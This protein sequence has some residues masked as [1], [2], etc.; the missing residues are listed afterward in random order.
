MPTT[1]LIKKRPLSCQRPYG[2]SSFIIPMFMY[3]LFQA[4]DGSKPSDAWFGLFS[5]AHNTKKPNLIIKISTLK[6]HLR[7]FSRLQMVFNVVELRNRSSMCNL[8]SLCF[9]YVQFL[10]YHIVIHEYEIQTS[11]EITCYAEKAAH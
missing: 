7:Y 6:S 11:G 9:S 2:E 5:I 4:S 8:Y 10:L 1:I 3:I